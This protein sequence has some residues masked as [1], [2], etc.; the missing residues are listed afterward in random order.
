MLVRQLHTPTSV[1]IPNAT[2][3]TPHNRIQ[4]FF[5]VELSWFRRTQMSLRESCHKDT[6]AGL[7]VSNRTTSSRFSPIRRTRQRLFRVVLPGLRL[8]LTRRRDAGQSTIEINN[9][10]V[11]R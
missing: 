4:H 5:D 9:S 1:L 8:G 7:S 11:H 10:G 6:E 3:E 2:Q